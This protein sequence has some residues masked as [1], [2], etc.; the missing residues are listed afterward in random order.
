MLVGTH[1]TGAPIHALFSMARG[2]FFSVEGV[3]QFTPAGGGDYVV[4]G[5]LGKASSAVWIEDAVTGRRVT[6]KIVSASP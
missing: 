5:E 2:T 4:K 1:E 6:E 3:I